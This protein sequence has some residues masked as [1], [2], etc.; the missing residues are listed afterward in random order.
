MLCSEFDARM[1]SLLD[2][3]KS[4]EVDPALLSH[5]QRCSSCHAQLA[6]L[7]RLLDSLDL[8]EVPDLPADFAQRVVD[9]IHRPAP[10][11]SPI[12]PPSTWMLVA[13][14]IAATLLLAVLPIAWYAMSNH[15]EVAQPTDE[16]TL[17]EG[18]T[19]QRPQSELAY[20]ESD[21][22]WLASLSLG[23]V[24]PE[25]THQRH[26][27]QVNQIANDLRPI[28]TPFNATMT[29]IR[30]SLPVGRSGAKGEPRAS[31]NRPS[32]RAEV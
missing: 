4:P 23:E 2:E 12:W 28:A 17:F 22:G 32:L 3:R 10:K 20:D 21:A 29:A 13:A 24:Y 27:Q 14:T 11:S 31:L 7:S 6:T 5:A 15:V 25:E 16:A 18:S 1:Q 19:E 9:S 30:R 8:L 26:R